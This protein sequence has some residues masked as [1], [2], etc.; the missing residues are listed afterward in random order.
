ME[1][2]GGPATEEGGGAPNPGGGTS[3][4]KEPKP[5]GGREAVGGK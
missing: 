3:E 2:G 4:T 1:E 5:T